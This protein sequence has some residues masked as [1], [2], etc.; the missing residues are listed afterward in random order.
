MRPQPARVAIDLET[1]GLHA[2][3]DA[4]IEIGAV[5]FAGK[6]ILDVFETF[7]APGIPLPY[8]I[9]RLTGI[10]PAQL[11]G[12]PA[13][14]TVLPSLR[15]FLGDLPLVGHNIPFERRVPTAGRSREAQCTDRY[16]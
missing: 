10:A 16:L 14:V 4:I 2:E 6:Q 11:R 15:S 5:K 3:Q 13:L 8:R 7:V 12:A 9:A 1:T